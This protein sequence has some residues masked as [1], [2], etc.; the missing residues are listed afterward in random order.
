MPYFTGLPSQRLLL[1]CYLLLLLEMNVDLQLDN[2][3]RI[4]KIN[5]VPDRCVKKTLGNG[6]K[7]LEVCKATQIGTILNHK[8]GRKPLI[9]HE[10]ENL[11]EI[12]SLQD[13]S[14]TD[15]KVADMVN[16]KFQTKFVRQ[17]IGKIR[18]KLGFRYRPRYTI[19]FLTK[20]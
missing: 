7:R 2:A 13:G 4:M 12:V 15:Q 20:N 18:R 10:I 11:I 1:K 6:S 9:T 8:R 14:L 3:A 5:S 16:E 19:Q 17:T